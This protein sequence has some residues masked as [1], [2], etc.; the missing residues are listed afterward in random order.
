MP[1]RINIGPENGPYVAINESSGNLQLEDNSGNVVA[2][3]DETNS[4]WDFANNTLA[5]IGSVNTDEAVIANRYHLVET[6]TVKDETDGPIDETISFEA[7]DIQHVELHGSFRSSDD[8][9]LRLQL[10][11][12]TNSEYN[13][14]NISDQTTTT[15]STSYLAAPEPLGVRHA[16]GC[17]D[18]FA[19]NAAEGANRPVFDGQFVSVVPLSQSSVVGGVDESQPEITSLRLFSEGQDSSQDARISATAVAYKDI[20]Q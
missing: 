12:Y 1:S 11:G 13:Y 2:E 20:Q 14:R 4:Q 10:N 18:I 17:I 3:W 6:Q 8:G 15:G 7:S 16:T 19:N 9:P 5:N